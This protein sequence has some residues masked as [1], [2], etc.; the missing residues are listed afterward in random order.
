MSEEGTNGT[1][2]V[3]DPISQDGRRLNV[4]AIIIFALP[5]FYLGTYLPVKLTAGLINYAASP[6]TGIDSFTDNLYA[7]ADYLV[8]ALDV[9]DQLTFFTAMTLSS[10]VIAATVAAYLRKLWTGTA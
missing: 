2:G 7:P 6:N 8:G 5:L 10:V 4:C 9:Q 3:L 1:S